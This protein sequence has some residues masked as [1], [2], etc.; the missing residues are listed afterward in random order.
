MASLV[1]NSQRR[2]A[3]PAV[4]RPAIGGLEITL[5]T[6][7]LGKKGS[8][9]A[10]TKEAL[11]FM[12]LTPDP[13]T[14]R[15]PMK[16]IGAGAQLEAHKDS[17]EWVFVD[18][19]FANSSRSYG[20]LVHDGEP[21]ELTFGDLQQ[22]LVHLVSASTTPLNLVLEAPLSVAFNGRENPVRRAIEKRDTVSRYWYVGLGCSV[23]VATTYL[24]RA[25]CECRRT[26]AVRLFEGLASFKPKGE[27]SSHAG[28]VCKLRELVWSQL[29][30][31]GS[32]IAP[33]DLLSPG[34]GRVESAFKVSG[35]DFRVPPVVMLR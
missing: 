33:E 22:R 16:E 29:P 10:T 17:G 27:K 6:N 34:Q 24:M 28:D 14:G 19:G 11:F 30:E 26:R 13:P 5:R 20:L 31:H 9:K 3:L 21:A 8:R 25:L 7:R 4:G 1:Q 35:M 2:Q 18:V 23:L 32:I 15:S 12:R